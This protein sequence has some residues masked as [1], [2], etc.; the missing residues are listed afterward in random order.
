[1][2]KPFA[3]AQWIGM[4][5]G[6]HPS[7]SL[8]LRRVFSCKPDEVQCAI[9]H[10]TGVGFYTAWLNG[11]PIGDKLLEP[12]QTN[13]EEVVFYSDYDV[14]D[15]LCSDNCL[16]VEL[17]DGW[18]HQNK[19]WRSPAVPDSTDAI[20]RFSFDC[21][22][23]VYGRPMMLCCLELQ[24][25]D[26]RTELIESDT[27]WKVH[28]GAIRSNNIYFGETY[29]ARY[30]IAACKAASYDDSHWEN[31]VVETQPIGTPVLS[32]MEPVRAIEEIRPISVKAQVNGIYIF[33]MGINF[34]GVV[35]IQGYG[36][37]GMELRLRYSET[38]RSDSSL[39]YDNY[40]QIV[41]NP[42]QEDR[43]IVGRDGW[44]CWQPTFVFHGFRYVEVSGSTYPLTLENLTGIRMHTDLRPCGTFSCS[45]GRMNQM[46]QLALNT[47]RSN[48]FGLPMDCPIR[49][50]C[51]WTGDA[52]VLAESLCY[53]YDADQF[54][55][56]YVEDLRTT[57]KV[58]GTFT[59]ISPGRRTCVPSCAAWGAAWVLIPWEHYR[60]YGDRE[61]LRRSFPDIQAW[62]AWLQEHE[63]S[64]GLL[65]DGLG[66]WWPPKETFV[67]VKTGP[68]ISNA[69]YFL[70]VKI[71]ARIAQELGETDLADAYM[72]RMEQV[73]QRFHEKFV[74]P[75]GEGLA[76]QGVM[77][78]ALEEDLIL[79]P[80]R[81]MVF[82]KLL[83][84][85]RN[86]A[87]HFHAGHVGIKYLFSAL[88]NG[89]AENVLMT[90]LHNDEYPGF[91]YMLNNGAT[92]L[93]E[94]W[95]GDA[96]FQDYREAYVGGSLNHPFK[97]SYVA[98]FYGQVLGIQPAAPGF[99]AIRIQPRLTRLLDHADGQY[100]AC[101]GKISV[102]W[103]HLAGNFELE[104]S[105]P[106]HI[107]CEVILPDGSRHVCSGC[108]RY[109]CSDSEG[110]P[111]DHP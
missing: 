86:Q 95:E 51:G 49:E 59:C 89:G 5:E 53:L 104:V 1:M 65:E 93:W 94:R 6:Y 73:R 98:W 77:A 61:I 90:V 88:V 39:Q 99:T 96:P 19:M 82:Q 110:F 42:I 45:D 108:G 44:F 71:A 22:N 23:P 28:D 69:Y 72:E 54:W 8:L 52:L 17:G 30:E 60:F 32:Q 24:Y 15:T 13:Y 87:Y 107:P 67:N 76:G 74:L 91:G 83:E 7:V 20:R 41:Y 57:K 62:I 50:R 9:L 18:F 70:S 48:L 75:A 31:A 12:A 25:G 2:I 10:I 80:Y 97:S 40:H 81:E 47:I 101:T 14:T 21:D 34:A 100:T 92:T 43:Y 79:P 68:V 84:D 36:F 46:Y 106:S 11:A 38:L 58:Y 66:D 78:M 35:R 63:A 29:D 109:V 111:Q 64:D 16:M 55:R 3:S 26:G 37:A 102:R 56:K 105:A 4:G 33:D 27:R 85:I 103:K